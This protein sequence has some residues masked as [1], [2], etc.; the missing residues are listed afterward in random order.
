[1][2][3][4]GLRANWRQFWLLVLINAFVGAMLG[5]ERAVVPLIASR[6]FGIASVGGS[7]SFIVSFGI[8]QVGRLL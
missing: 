6:D 5:L 1:M 8:F 4:A 2:P 7:L 3:E